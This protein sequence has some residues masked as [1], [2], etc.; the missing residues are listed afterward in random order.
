MRS[1]IL[2]FPLLLLQFVAG[3]GEYQE[4][5]EFDALDIASRDQ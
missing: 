1:N 4:G 3:Q 5:A 2:I